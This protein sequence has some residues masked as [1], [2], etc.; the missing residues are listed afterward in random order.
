MT[1][2]V[3]ARDPFQQALPQSA[4][5]SAVLYRFVA[6]LHG[7]DSLSETYEA[8]LDAMLD[9]LGCQRASVLIRD[10]TG[11]MR[12]VGWRNLS[13]DYRRAVEGHS[14]WTPDDPN[15][16]PVCI[17][18]IA[19]EPL[20]EMLKETIAREGIGALGFFPLLIN[21][22][23][24]GKFMTYYNH[25]H[26]FAGVELDLC[27]SIARQLALGIERR[28]A[29]HTLRASEQRL[30]LALDAGRMGSWEWNVLTGGITWSPELEA[31]H[32]LAPGTF[33]GTFEAYQKDIH[34]DDRAFV[35]RSIADSLDR[36]EHHLEYRIVLPDGAIRWVESRGKVFRDDSGVIA[37]LVG[38]CTDITERKRAEQALKEADRRKD[39]FLATLAHE[40]RNPLAPIRTGV[41]ILE[42]LGIGDPAF[43][44]VRAM[45]H[46]QVKQLTR[47]VDDLLDVSRIT[48]NK[49]ELRKEPTQLADVVALAVEISRPIIDLHQHRLTVDLPDERIVLNADPGRL[50][51]AF[52]NLLNNAAKY[53]GDR[54]QIDV[55]ARREGD[56]V[57]FRVRDYGIGISSQML[58]RVFDMFAQ[59]DDS[60]THAQGG[61]GIGLTIVKALVEMHDGT[62]RARSG[63]AGKGSEFE[64]TLPILAAAP[65][66]ASSNALDVASG[67]VSSS[68]ARRVLMVDDNVDA[69][70]SLG[71]LL[72]MQGHDVRT[73]NDAGSALRVIE[74]YIPDVVLLD[75]GLPGKNGYELARE[76]RSMPS[77]KHVLL[78]ATTGFG[79]EEDKR[80]A[81][82]AGFDVHLVK[83]VD[84][85]VLNGLLAEPAREA[86]GF[87]RNSSASTTH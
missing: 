3:L 38:V 33:G 4:R 10:G 42:R 78:V 63:G 20:D 9:A 46:R 28:Q 58:P 48:R 69:A 83:P 6:R 80:R 16:Q 65:A 57:V 18:S 36:G 27:F 72:A 76:M 47:L 75:I 43:D 49:I 84:P 37:R 21:G 55:S 66:S 22:K 85:D 51:Q 34:P 79:Q 50:A 59:A 17:S 39:E 82:D 87:P 68:R 2:D 23:L 14:P 15:P 30:R 25:P 64:L 74:T 35:R 13:D 24:G 86:Q 45:M 61:L 62:V 31:I 41:D 60:L 53:S 1:A 52:A 54:N 56:R 40:L 67:G 77:L 11:V 73:A 7:A 26:V 29:E 5:Q 12:F 81:K 19:D 32:G 71:M 44:N 70:S 8:G